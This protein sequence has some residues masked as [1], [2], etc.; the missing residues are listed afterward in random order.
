MFFLFFLALLV[1]QTSYFAQSDT[2]KYPWPT[3][4]FNSSKGLNATFGEFRNTGSADHFH[5]AVDIGAPDGN[6]VYPCIDGIVHHIYN[7]GYDSYINIR[8]TIDGMKKHITYYHVVPNPSLVIDQSVKAS[9]TIIGTIYVG[10]AHVHL[11]ERELVNASSSSFGTAINPI[12]P[13]GGL[14]P[15]Q[16]SYAPVIS[17]SSLRFFKDESSIQ[18]PSNLLNG[19]IDIRVDVR[20][21]NG[22]TSSNSNNGTYIL[23]YR[24]LSE[25]GNQVI[26]EPENEGVKYR[27][28]NLPSNNYVHNAFVKGIA[29]LSDPIY[30]LTNG[31][32]EKQINETLTIQNNYLDTDL[33]YG[34][35]YQLEIFSEDTR[36]NKTSKRF[37]ISIS[38]LPPELSA[39][40]VNNDSF[41]FSWRPYLLNN[42]K[43]YRIYYSDIDSDSSWHLVA[44]EFMLHNETTK[45]IFENS[46]SFLEPT[47]TTNLKYYL[48]AIDS[49]GNES[50]RSDIYSTIIQNKNAPKLL[51][52][53][54][55]DRYGGNGSWKEPN[56]DFNTL[57]SISTQQAIW[58]FNI[59]SS[60]NEAVINETVN[61]IDYDMV[62]WFLG[63]ES[64]EGN[65]LVNTE[66]YK[67]ALYL[68]NGGKLFI[69][70][71]DIGQ[72]LDTKHNYNELF[73]DTLFYHQ[74]LKANLIHDGNNLLFEVN[75]EENS[76]FEGLNIPFGNVYPSD[77]PDDIEPVNGS[78][79]ILNYT[80]MRDDTTYRKG[81]IAYTG[82]FGEK[83]NTGSLVYLSFPFETIADEDIRASL[84][85][86][87]QLYLGF[88]IVGITNE[89]NK[90][91]II[92][93]FELKQNYPNPFNPT[94]T[95]KYKIP[96]ESNNLYRNITITVFD[97]LGREIKSL[98]NKKQTAG[99]Y[100]INF[101]AS[102]FPSG[103][104]YYQL[105]S[106]NFIET[107]KM[108]LLK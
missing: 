25:D 103:V 95:I 24:V 87:I 50:S 51:I 73:S 62:I 107:K 2:T 31:H 15:Y 79:P 89:E 1:S 30:W 19:K 36:T 33:F 81:G 18:V 10:A 7:N 67:L 88:K 26:F 83:S 105:N 22:T 85:T 76:L 64:I 38:K 96:N 92:S 84:M 54:G 43:G 61:L 80:Y 101:D 49:S 14:S 75:G 42:L 86:Q 53:D 55:F 11:I 39:V 48:S 58:Y 68:E 44:D 40:L 63:D 46:S 90:L 69:T 106:D 108:I 59:S 47:T 97:I 98:V 6:P 41:T 94:T 77:S 56:H 71:E 23:G 35:N 74:Y 91:S 104:Y 20:E 70:G 28:Y 3:P 99:N 52:V 34:G 5:N 8:S 12:R 45:I 9:Q 4:S 16:D 66:Q 72:D 21:K 32:G 17:G 100:S 29:T 13:E 37:P 102:D 82:S 60:S 57:Y 93:N 65:T 27:F 78:V